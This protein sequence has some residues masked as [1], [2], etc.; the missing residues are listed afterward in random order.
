MNRAYETP[1]PTIE[2]QKQKRLSICTAAPF[3]LVPCRSWRAPPCSSSSSCA[4]WPRCWR[5]CWSRCWP[6]CWPRCWFPPSLPSGVCVP[7]CE[8][9]EPE[10]SCC[11]SCWSPHGC[12]SVLCDREDENTVRASLHWKIRDFPFQYSRRCKGLSRNRPT[13]SA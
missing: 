2:K 8:E 11:S 6:R 1:C 3:R 7:G 5:R 10:A 13:H 9:R 12:S 4:C